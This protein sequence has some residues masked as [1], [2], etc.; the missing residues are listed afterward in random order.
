MASE[1]IKGLSK[2]A[3]TTH[4]IIAYSN[5]VA[6]FEQASFLCD[7][8]TLVF[9]CCGGDG[10]VAIGAGDATGHYATKKRWVIAYPGALSVNVDND[11]PCTIERVS[12]KVLVARYQNE[13]SCWKAISRAVRYDGTSLVTRG[14]TE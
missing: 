3:K 2:T 10:Y 6:F 11:V 4:I 14:T 1:R 7:N 9:A 8:R 12:V 5:N 13:R